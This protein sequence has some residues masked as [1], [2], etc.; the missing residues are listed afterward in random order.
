MSV[1]DLKKGAVP[2]EIPQVLEHDKDSTVQLGSGMVPPGIPQVL[3]NQ[4]T[5]SRILTGVV[6]RKQNPN[7]SKTSDTNN[8]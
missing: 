4:N 7:G 1:R 6:T 2:P 5:T 3:S 8:R